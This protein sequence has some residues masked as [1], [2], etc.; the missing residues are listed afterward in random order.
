MDVSEAGRRAAPA[1]VIVVA[2]ALLVSLL[3]PSASSARPDREAVLSPI[4]FEVLD[5]PQPVLA[6]D[7]RMHLAYEIQAVNQSSRAI[8]VI[9]IQARAQG[10][11]IGKP[12]SGRNLIERTRLNNG[13]SG[14]A[15]LGA[16]ESAV[17]FLD[18]SY[19]RARRIPGSI[20][21]AIT[22][23]WPNP[24]ATEETVRQTI[25]GVGSRVSAREVPEVEPPLRG[26]NWV[27]ASSCCTLNPHRAAT[28]AVD[29]TI[30][31]PERFAIDFIRLNPDD[32]LFEGLL[33]DL[34]SYAYFGTRIHSATAGT[35]VRVRDGLPEQVPGA[36][37]AGSTIQNAA[38]NHV[39]VR[40]SRDRYALYAHMKT[41]STRV[42]IGDKVRAGTVLGLLGNSG[43]ASA[44]HLHF[45]I[46]DSPSPIQS[47]GLPFTFRSFTG[48]GFV[49]DP[50]GMVEGGDPRIKRNRLAGVHRDR[51]VLDY[52]IVNF[53]RPQS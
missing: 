11:R 15:R 24:V 2:A 36:L 20:R 41:G 29:G 5:A 31:V 17:F 39:V 3:T 51:M 8:S 37:P 19:S 12:L 42:K 18:T 34:G 43:N 40:I 9:R 23:A 45:Q 30:R 52:Q 33:T 14:N 53:G 50:N 35:V 4:A 16:G 22:M 10:A 13:T 48:Q 49:T 6:S 27:T 32:R 25:L 7:G 1:A 26:S 21:H 44:P 28:L 38:G 47:N 46:M